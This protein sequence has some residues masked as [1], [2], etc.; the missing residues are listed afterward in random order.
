MDWLLK[1][2]DSILFSAGHGLR[3]SIGLIQARLCKIQEL[4]KDCSG[5]LSHFSVNSCT[6]L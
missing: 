3:T 2:R 5:I 1:N 6:I 4:F